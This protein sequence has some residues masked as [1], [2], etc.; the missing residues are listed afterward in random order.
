MSRFSR[1]AQNAKVGL[2]G[3]DPSMLYLVTDVLMDNGFDVLSACGPED[4]GHLV[5]GQGPDVVIC[6]EYGEK[7]RGQ[8][9]LDF[10]R[11]CG[12]WSQIPFVLLTDRED[13]DYV[14][15]CLDRGMEDVLSKPFRIEELRSRVCKAVVHGR[16]DR[17]EK[18]G[19]VSLE[20]TLAQMALPDLLFHLHQCRATGLLQA[21][22]GYETFQILV[23]DGE[24]VNAEGPDVM[25]GRKAFFRAIR[26]ARGTFRFTA[27]PVAVHGCEDLRPLPNLVLTAVQ[28][29]D[30]YV[31]VRR[32]L[33]GGAIFLAACR[34]ER[35]QKRPLV[36]EPMLR[37]RG[38]WTVDSLIRSCPMTDLEA[39]RELLDLI[40]SEVLIVV[41]TPPIPAH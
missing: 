13:S 30:E 21:G 26:C 29:S 38:G 7:C 18:L 40:T 10:I 32:Q 6:D 17:L 16:R 24:L 20:G 19:D 41:D 33:P 22:Q 31:Q 39:A 4:L 35:L 12:P 9:I 36:V 3:H 1:R 27:G 25:S 5:E 28:E 11:H 34:L 14:A 37:S 2:V 23:K 15:R 8:M